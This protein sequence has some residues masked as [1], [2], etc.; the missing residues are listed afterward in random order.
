MMGTVMAGC[1]ATFARFARPVS[2]GLA[3]LLL[4][5]A[6]GPA[7]ERTTSARLRESRLPAQMPQAYGGGEVVLELAVD[8]GGAVSRIDR[9]RVTPPYADVVASAAAEW[10]F[11]PATVRREGRVTDVASSVL[12]VAAF[13]PASFYAGPA[14]GV[15]PEVVGAPSPHVPRVDPLV[16]PA[17][18]PTATGDGI[19]LVE[20]EM[21]GRAEPRTYRIVGPRSGFDAAALEAVRAWQFRA[22]QA[23]DTPDRLFVYAMVGFRV[24]L[25]PTTPRR[26]RPGVRSRLTRVPTAS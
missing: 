17:Y 14:P 1:S 10:R 26:E 21:S 15:A 4:S 5:A 24:P 25:G 9:I 12:V 6:A 22:P 8:S 7:I 13:R 19:V 20:I 3:T 23:D 2:A 16:M 11:D 18:P